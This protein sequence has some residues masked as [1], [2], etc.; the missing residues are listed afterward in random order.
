MTKRDALAGLGILGVFGLGALLLVVLVPGFF[1]TE[2]SFPAT[3]PTVQAK[4][5]APVSDNTGTNPTTTPATASTT[6]IDIPATTVTLTFTPA[7]SARPTLAAP[8]TTPALAQRTATTPQVTQRPYTLPGGVGPSDGARSCPQPLP[9]EQIKN[10]YLGY[11]EA[12]KKAYKT[13]NPGLLEP[14]VDT[15]ARDGKLWQGE[16]DAILKTK[17]GGYWL[18]YQ[19][20]HSDPLI[21]KINPYFGGPGQCQVSVFDGTKLT[22]LAKKSGTDEPFNKDNPKPQIQQYKLSHSF[23]MVVQ[24]GRWVIAGE[25]AGEL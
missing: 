17:Q 21:I 24:N 25:G 11:W 20:E 12:M 23:E 14:F 6:I 1:A 10:D 22:V 16:S 18:D 7:P 13:G 8:T 9:L 2:N 4:V 5:S 19:I 15:K 3:T